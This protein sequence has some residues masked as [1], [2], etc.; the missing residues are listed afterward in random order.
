M[1]FIFFIYLFSP[2]HLSSFLL[3]RR[4]MCC[5]ARNKLLD[6]VLISLRSNDQ[7]IRI[8]HSAVRFSC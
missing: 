5:F 3:P 6:Y 7:L 4:A 2:L 8:A 1:L